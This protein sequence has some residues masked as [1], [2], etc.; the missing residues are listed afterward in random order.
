VYIV[1]R[2]SSYDISNIVNI[3][4]YVVYL[5]VRILNCTARTHG[6]IFINTKILTFLFDT[7]T[8]Y[9]FRIILPTDGVYVTQQHKKLIFVIAIVLS[10]RQDPIFRRLNSLLL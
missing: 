6:N 3:F 5:S 8:V 7:P 2:R 9:E 1:T 4:I 10:V